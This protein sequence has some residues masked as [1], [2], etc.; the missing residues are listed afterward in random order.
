MKKYNIITILLLSL[1]LMFVSCDPEQDDALPLGTPP[2]NV[3]FEV[4]PTG[5]LNTFRLTNTTPGTF[6]HQW[7]L[8]NGQTAVGDEVVITYQ[9]M[10][11]YMVTLKAFNDGG[12]GESSRTI[13][14]LEDAPT[15]CNSGSLMEFVS[16]CDT[17]TWRL[18]PGEGAYWV[19]PDPGTTWWTNDQAV[20]D[21]RPCAFNDEWIFTADGVM[22]YDTKG[23]L[24]AE[25]YMGFNFECVTDGQLSPDVAAWASG[26][27]S[28]VV[29]EGGVEQLELIGQGA[30]IGLPKAANGA[31]VTSP[32]PGVTY[33]IIERGTNG[34]Q[35]FMILQVDYTVG[36]WRFHIVSN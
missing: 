15:P 10:G 25:D 12:F 35:D 36:L 4:S 17:K 29:S 32:Q 14:V 34:G 18:L 1:T 28:F 33:D 22:E 23:D 26:T 27:H 16:N 11:D 8:G 9:F 19:G 24:W 13:S 31:E 5:D 6:I 30:F 2:S 7:N 21:E 3:S 20:V